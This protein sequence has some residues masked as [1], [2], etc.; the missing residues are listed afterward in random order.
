V[1]E[2][3]RSWSIHEDE[4]SIQPLGRRFDDEIKGMLEQLNEEG[5]LYPRRSAAADSVGKVLRS[6]LLGPCSPALSS[7]VHRRKR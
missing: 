1:T 2:E 6:G 3:R 4:G 7:N 5:N